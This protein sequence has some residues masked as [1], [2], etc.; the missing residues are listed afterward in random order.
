MPEWW[1][2][3]LSDFLM[4]TPATYYRLFERYNIALWP[5]QL[6]TLAVGLTL[7]A[8]A[9]RRG[10]AAHPTVAALLAMLW[11]WVSWAFHWRRYASIN[12]AATWFAGAFLLEALLLLG[13]SLLRP[14]PPGGEAPRSHRVGLAISLFG[15]MLQPLIGP[16]MG[17]SWKGVEL[18]GLAPDPTATV[19]LGLLLTLGAPA[20]LLVIPVLWCA[21]TWATLWAMEAREAWVML[22]AGLLAVGGL[23]ARRV[24][25]KL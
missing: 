7:V 11:L 17:R 22:F 10:P 2:Y 4:F 16:L 18:F 23:V 19:T 9:W 21:V 12:L 1:T 24:K 25:G 20:S 6:V 5:S 8:L 15:L 3:R 13:W 14:R